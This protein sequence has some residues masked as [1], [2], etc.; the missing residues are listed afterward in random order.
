LKNQAGINAN[1]KQG[2]QAQ[3]TNAKSN[4]MNIER[5]MMTATPKQRNKLQKQWDAENRKYEAAKNSYQS[6][7]ATS[8][9]GLIGE[10]IGAKAAEPWVAR[11]ANIQRDSNQF[12]A[13]KNNSWEGLKGDY[14]QRR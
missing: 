8:V 3:M 4:M 7:G 1:S 13:A 14:Y 2:Y 11:N 10:K 6:T 12:G 9:L 5:A